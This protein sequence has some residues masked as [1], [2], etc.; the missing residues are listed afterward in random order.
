MTTTNRT[1][2]ERVAYG[3]ALRRI[4]LSISRGWETLN[5]AG[6]RLVELPPEI[7]RLTSLTE[8][9]LQGN[10]LATMPPEIGRLESLRALNVSANRLVVLP[11]E[12]GRLTA[13]T[14]LALD[15]NPLQEPPMSVCSQGV[16]A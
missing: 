9:F 7:G 12:I 15:E 16:E 3:E 4:E 5:L 6:L 8:L 14:R 1:D 10:R 13:L 2:A 11:A